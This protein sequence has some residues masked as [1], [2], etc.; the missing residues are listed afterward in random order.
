MT[1]QP[2]ATDPDAHADLLAREETLDAAELVWSTRILWACTHPVGATSIAA[3]GCTLPLARTATI[4]AR[5]Y[6]IYP[7]PRPK[8]C[9]RQGWRSSDT[10][11][12][13][14]TPNAT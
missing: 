2:V 8:R 14:A 5:L 13:R 3:S 6:G 11:S 4:L 10:A 9:P 12:S 7:T 1:V